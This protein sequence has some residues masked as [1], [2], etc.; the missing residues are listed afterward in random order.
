M[1]RRTTN[2]PAQVAEPPA[3]VEPDYWTVKDAARYM[4]V[5]TNT[6]YYWIN[7]QK[8]GLKR[9]TLT[10]PPA[11]AIRYGRNCIRIPIQK[12]KEWAC[13]LKPQGND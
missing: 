7:D 13:N 5:S 2:R 10:G 9:V 6:I 12:F 3:S 4:R 11:P 1:L 8:T